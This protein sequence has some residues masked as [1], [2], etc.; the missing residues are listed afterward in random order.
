MNYAP[1]D[2]HVPA[3]ER[4]NRTISERV[5]VTYHSLPYKAMPKIMLQHLAMMSAWQLNLFPVKGGVSSCY[6][7]YVIMGG[8]PLNYKKH[9][10][11]PF[12]SY[13]Q[14]TLRNDPTNINGP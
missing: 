14:G 10:M 3:A 7:P 4:N 2:E 8:V 6:S 1:R 13:V 9:L 12:G 5:R 11:F